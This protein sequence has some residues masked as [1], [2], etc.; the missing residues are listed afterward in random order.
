[1]YLPSLYFCAGSYALSYRQRISAQEEQI[2]E[3]IAHIFPTKSSTTFAAIY[4]SHGVV[5]SSHRT[6]A[7]LSLDDVNTALSYK[8]RRLIVKMITQ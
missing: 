2:N 4:I 1:M 5:A 3:I 7:G 8:L 6:I